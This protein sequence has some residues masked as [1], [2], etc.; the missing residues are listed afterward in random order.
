M[1]FT[2]HPLSWNTTSQTLFIRAIQVNN[3]VY[4]ATVYGFT[5]TNIE[6]T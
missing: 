4:D 6:Y 5:N 2:L 1:T 3:N